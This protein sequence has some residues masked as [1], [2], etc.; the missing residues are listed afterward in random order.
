MGVYNNH[1]TTLIKFLQSFI[2]EEVILGRDVVFANLDAVSDVNVLPKQDIVGLTGYEIVTTDVGQDVTAGF[3]VITYGDVNNFRLAIL[4][5]RLFEKTQPGR[6]MPL[7]DAETGAPLGLLSFREGS[8]VL[9]VVDGGEGR[10]AS[11]IQT[12]LTSDRSVASRFEITFAAPSSIGTLPAL[13]LDGL[14]VFSY[15][16]AATFGGASLSYSLPGSPNWFLINPTTGLISGT[17]PNLDWAATL[18]VQA[19]N[20][21]G[22]ATTTVDVDVTSITV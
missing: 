2:A 8:Q 3:V 22:L 20:S 16:A 6:T 7:I 21:S 17:A 14:Q 13:H 19:S 9:P 15:D 1:R 4:I 10:D 5:D 18:T 11:M 12:L